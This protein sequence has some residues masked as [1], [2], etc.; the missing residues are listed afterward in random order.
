MASVRSLLAKW[1]GGAGA[2]P[3]AGVRS[4]LARWLGGAGTEAP[5]QGG[6]VG[7]GSADVARTRSYEGSGGLVFGGS[8]T[9]TQISGQQ[10]SSSFIVVFPAAPVFPFQKDRDEVKRLVEEVYRVQIDDLTA[11]QILAIAKEK[12]SGD[13]SVAVHS[14]AVHDLVKR[15]AAATGQGMHSASLSNEILEI[16]DEEIIM[17]MAA[18]MR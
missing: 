7:G 10:S 5:S 1:L 11:D 8:A 18:M 4:L 16:E 13:I 12:Y 2:A 15:Y 9:V 6:L 14:Q 17:L 3:P